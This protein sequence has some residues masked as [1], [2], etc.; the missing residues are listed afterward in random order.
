MA[1]GYGLDYAALD[2]FENREQFSEEAVKYD[3]TLMVAPEAPP[4][5]PKD[6]VSLGDEKDEQ[7][8]RGIGHAGA[9]VAR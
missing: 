1:E 5:A 4:E 2:K 8:Y 9:R 6:T 3:R 7:N